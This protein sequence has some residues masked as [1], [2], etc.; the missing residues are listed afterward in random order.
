MSLKKGQQIEVR[1]EKVAFGGRGLAKVDGMTVFVDQTV[2][3]DVA[4]V[5]V[6]RRKKNYAEARLV[7]LIEPSPHRVKAP[8]PY[9]G[10][11]GG[12]KWQFLDY[13]KQLEYKRQHVAEAI[14]HL[15]LLDHVEVLPTLPSPKQFEYRNKM[16]FSASD[17]RWLLPEELAILEPKRGIALGLH[18][19]GTY[20]KV[21]D[22]DACLLQPDLGNQLL[23]HVKATIHGSSRPVYGLKSHQGFWRFL[24]L[25]HSEASDRWMANLITTRE[26]RSAVEPL[27][28]SLQERFPQVSSVVNNI[29]AR[30]SGVAVGEYEI[31]LAGEAHIHD[32]IGGLDFKISANSFFQTNTRGAERLFETVKTF[33]E[34]AAG[35]T[36]A[37]L[38]SGT[39]T[40]ALSLARQARQVIGFEMVESAVL[41]AE[42]NCRRNNITNCRFIRGDLRESL[43]TASLRPD[44]MIIDPP[45]VG[46][47]KEVIEQ[48]LAMAPP[49]IVYVSCNPATLARDLG[50]M[51]EAYDVLQVQP[52]DMFPHTFHI[53]AIARMRRKNTRRAA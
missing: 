14:E 21:L 13:T 48:V 9:S 20:Y 4:L 38:Y 19:P 34:L 26:D 30:R 47:H 53:E 8:C 31:L 49:V 41:D 25:R 35:Q 17:R 43:K 50:L 45:R 33:A 16:E 12:C 2:P 10:I 22:I 6:F 37:D 39:G 5:Q 42:S 29:T 51:K 32:R 46:M 44:V 36:V 28:Q 40:I 1:I 23:N 7:T 52:V 24:T 3:Q 18:V 15:A 27:A 11:C